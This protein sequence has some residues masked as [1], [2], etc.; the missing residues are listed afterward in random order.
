MAFRM[1][2][3]VIH[4]TKKHSVL[5]KEAEVEEKRTHGGD[6]NIVEAASLYGQSMDPD[7]IDFNIRRDK[8]EWGKK[9]PD[10]TVNVETRKANTA[11][12]DAAAAKKRLADAAR[13]RTRLEREALGDAPEPTSDLLELK[14]GE[15][16]EYPE[17]TINWDEII[18]EE[19][20]DPDDIPKKKEK[21][22]VITAEPPIVTKI[23]GKKTKNFKTNYTK[24]EQERLVFSEEHNRMVLPEELEN[25]P[26]IETDKLKGKDKREMKKAQKGGRNK[27]QDI[28]YMLAGPSTRAK[29]RKEGYVPK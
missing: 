28:K 6:P 18:E 23:G 19:Q 7:V 22:E 10:V 14:T 11:E 8:I 15:S 16:Y 2:K 26:I 1:N 5:R 4:G 20:D 29:M 12:E 21:K 17:P 13:E 3:P 9:K 27:L 25:K 24:S